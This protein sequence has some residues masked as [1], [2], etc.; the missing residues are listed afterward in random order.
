MKEKYQEIIEIASQRGYTELNHTSN[1]R[2]ITLTNL[3]TGLGL[4]VN[5]EEETFEIVSIH[6]MFIKLTT[7]SCGSFKDNKHFK[8]FEH[9]MFVYSKQLNNYDESI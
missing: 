5:T 8:K 6:K 7:G 3:D 1:F 9:K 2:T 4:I